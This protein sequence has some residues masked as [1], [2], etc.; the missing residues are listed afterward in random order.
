MKLCYIPES[1]VSASIYSQEKVTRKDIGYSSSVAVM[2]FASVLHV[3]RGYIHVSIY[4]WVY[5]YIY[6]PQYSMQCLYFLCGFVFR[7]YFFNDSCHPQICELVIFLYI[8]IFYVLFL[9]QSD[10]FAKGWLLSR[11]LIIGFLYMNVMVFVGTVRVI[12]RLMFIYL[13]Y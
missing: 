1:D 5:V 10:L 9:V 11:L 7:R 2:H 6:V 3:N 4:I 12:G 8:Y 13:I